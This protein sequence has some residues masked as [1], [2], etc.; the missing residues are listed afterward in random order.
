MFFNDYEGAME[1]FE[2]AASRFKV[3]KDYNRAGEAYVR[4]GDCAVKCKD[5]AAASQAYINAVN[6]Y[7]KTDLKRAAQLLDT[8]IR[9]QIDSN[10]LSG[11][12]RLE[13]EFADALYEAGQ[14]MEAVPHYEKA[15]QYFAAEDMKLQAQ[16][17][18]VAMAKIYGEND[19]FDK[20]LTLYER[21]GNM[22]TE[23]PLRHDAKEY[24]MRAMLCRLA[25]VRDDNRYEKSAEAAEALSTY[26]TRDIYLKNTREAEFLQMCT[27][28]VEGSDIE[29]FETAVSLLQ[30][31]RKLDDWKTHVLLVVKRNMESI[32]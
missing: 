4:A 2:K 17:C 11:A 8:A 14:T 20:A 24:F 22:T 25:T 28:A 6:A 9:A 27:E 32:L 26:M 31:I 7:R 21:L 10:R 3:D 29:K 30:E 13:K 18:T 16:S 12:A 19:E 23:G 1:L 5:E 15:V